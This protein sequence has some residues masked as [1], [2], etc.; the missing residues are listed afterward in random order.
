MKKIILS[1]VAIFTIGFTHAQKAEFGVKGG[2]N[3]ASLIFVG[4]GAPVT[5]PLVGINAGGFVEVKISEKFSIQPELLYTTQG[6]NF[7]LAV[8]FE[9]DQYDTDNSFKLSYINIPVMFKYYVDK[10][11]S[12]EG[13]PQIGFLTSSKLEV[14]V[15]GQSVTQDA[16]DYF[17][18]V[19]FGLNIGAGYDFTKKLS[20]SIR[21]N[22][23]LINIG[24]D[25]FATGDDKV[26]NRVLSISLGCK[27]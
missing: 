13:G 26:S 2:L 23:G 14:K 18:S 16:K 6:S 4:E 27:L 19:D 8:D 3:I 22:I 21:Y 7:D 5:T 11:F 10:K 9:G 24:S 25:E 12:L 20:A 1:T 17:E 15:L